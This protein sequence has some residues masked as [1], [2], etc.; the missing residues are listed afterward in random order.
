MPNPFQNRAA[1]ISG[2]A[3]DIIPVVPDDVQD[4]PSVAVSL[5]VEGGETL[6]VVTVNGQT[7]TL[8]VTDF[9]ILPVGVSRVNLT[10][11]TASGIHALVLV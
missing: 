3:T 2:P 1:S 10:G 11:T 6:S 8:Q 7:R 4:L 5:Y 9:S